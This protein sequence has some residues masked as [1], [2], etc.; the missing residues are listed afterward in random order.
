MSKIITCY[1][2]DYQNKKRRIQVYLPIN[3]DEKKPYHVLY[4]HDGQ[5]V[6]DPQFSYSGL[7][8]NVDK[9]LNQLYNENKIAL[10]V[11]AIDN[12]G[13][14]RFN[15]YSPFT[16]VNL[17][18]YISWLKPAY[19]GGLGVNYGDWLVNDLIPFVNKNY[20]TNKNIIAGSSMGGYISLY[21][22]YKYPDLF[23]AVGAFSTAI[24]FNKKE[25][26]NFVETNFNSNT[27][28]YLDI[29]T[30]E[31]SDINNKEFNQIYLNDTL[32]LDQIFI[33]LKT[34][35]K[36]LVV[37]QGGIHSESAWE[38]R[39]PDFITWLFQML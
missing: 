27:I 10:I 1:L 31:T 22:A 16:S 8:W 14:N 15:E 18:D 20:C 24:W 5:N 21:I 25:L 19:H 3:Y 37:D 35:K 6:F 36:Q 2:K 39:F 33:K 4:L 17:N 9:T 38:K 26:F 29:G 12:D 23:H 28:V 30:N 11:V 32:E 34:P 7:S 13:A